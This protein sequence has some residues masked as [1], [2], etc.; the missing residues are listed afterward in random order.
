M[1]KFIKVLDTII[2][3]DWLISCWLNKDCT[4]LKIRQSENIT[5]EFSG[6]PDELKLAFDSIWEQIKDK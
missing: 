1:K 4:I 3:T 5:L 2:D 6:K